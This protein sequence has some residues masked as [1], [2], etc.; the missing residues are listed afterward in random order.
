M[1]KYFLFLL[2]VTFAAATHI[3]AQQTN[4]SDI[5]MWNAGQPI[6]TTDTYGTIVK[7]ILGKLFVC[8]VN[9]SK[10]HNHLMEVTATGQTLLLYGGP[11]N[12]VIRHS[13]GVHRKRRL[14]PART[15]QFFSGSMP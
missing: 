10:Y 8:I 11:M 9:G 12:P 14:I 6:I 13:H 15:K 7:E 5:Y 4:C 1:K 2:F 3:E